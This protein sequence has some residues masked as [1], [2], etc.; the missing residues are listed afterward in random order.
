M[1]DDSDHIIADVRG[2]CLSA[3][4]EEDAARGWQVLL[5]AAPAAVADIAGKL[6]AHDF[7]LSFI[8]AVH[9]DPGCEL[10]YQFCHYARPL[11][12]HLRVSAPQGQ[13]VPSLAAVYQGA[14]WHEREIRDFFG[15]AFAGHPGLKPLI[16]TREDI[17]RNPLL[18]HGALRKRR[19]E[20]FTE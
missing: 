1:Q 12:V 11:R 9:A 17:G 2:L 15:I 3:A 8:T 14:A 18:K 4:R 6:R 10:V 16:L 7:F 20:L 13:P 5:T 19:E